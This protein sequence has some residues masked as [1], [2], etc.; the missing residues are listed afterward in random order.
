MKCYGDLE[1]N[2]NKLLSPAFYSAASLPTEP[3]KGELCFVDSALYICVSIIGTPI[4]IPLTNKISSY[5]HEQTEE[6][7]VWDVNHGL[8]Q[9]F[10][11]THV[12]HDDGRQLI[13]DSIEMVDSNNVQVTFQGATTGR[14]ACAAASA[15]GDGFMATPDHTHNQ[16]IESD[17]W[18][19]NHRLGFKPLVQVTIDNKFVFPDYVKHLSVSEVEIGFILPKSGIARLI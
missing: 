17:V 14:V 16:T 8:G 10:V 2:Q 1:F 19:V 18:T 13:P 5:I 11:L 6:S 15:V 9:D 7:A 12:F 3:S 4:W